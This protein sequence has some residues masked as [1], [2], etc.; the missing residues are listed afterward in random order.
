MTP[1][2]RVL[3][4]LDHREPDKVPIDCSGHRSSGIAAVAYPKLREALGLAPRP[5]YVYDPVQQLAI[6]DDDVLDLLSIDTIE[7]GRGFSLEGTAWAD[8]TL[9]D[10]TP[11][12]MPRWATPQR[13][14][15]DWVLRSPSGRLLGLLPEGAYFFDQA[16]WPFYRHDDLD[17]I[18]EA[19][20]N[21]VWGAFPGPPG[22]GVSTSDLAEGARQLRQ[23]TD[24]AIIGLFGGNLLETGQMCYRMDKF[25]MMLGDEPRRVHAFLDRLT[26][27]HMTKLEEFLGAVGGHIDVILFGDDLGG[28]TAPLLSP[29]MYREFFKPRHAMLWQ[30]AKQ[31]ANVKVMLHCCGA[32]RPLLRDMI[33]SGLDAINPVQIS[34]KGMEAAG[35]KRDFGR[36][37]TFWGGGCDTQRILPQGTP[38]EVRA[39]VRQQ[40]RILAPGGGFIFQQ[41]HNIQANVPTANILAMFETVREERAAAAT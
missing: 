14:G 33:E 29:Q 19:L 40:T 32:V 38:E 12:K 30:R 31:L 21:N 27:R 37:L 18:E 5:V 35:L 23:K 24:R 39:H 4:A 22:P 28:Q 8:W 10:G 3:A 1:R 25:M 6:L 20:S 17:H 26:E 41:V 16:Y 15:S 11:C 13:E 9:P 7:L 34:G 2:E 36:D